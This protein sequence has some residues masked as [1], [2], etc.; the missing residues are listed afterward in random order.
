MGEGCCS[1]GMLDVTV[2]QCPIPLVVHV[3]VEFEEYRFQTCLIKVPRNNMDM[4]TLYC[5]LIIS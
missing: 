3:L 2:V 5:L 4:C 1:V